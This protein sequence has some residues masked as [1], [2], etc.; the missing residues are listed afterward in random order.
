MTQTATFKVTTKSGDA[1]TTYLM[2]YT[3]P[4]HLNAIYQ[5]AR[6]VWA[7]YFV[8]AVTPGFEM[9]DSH[10]YQEQ[11]AFEQEELQWKYMNGEYEC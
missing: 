8:T 9:S 1:V 2:E 6:Q 5:E 3:S 10:T 11:L 7:E 4:K